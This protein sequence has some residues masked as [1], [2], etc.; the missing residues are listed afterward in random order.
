M[1]REQ[2]GREGGVE[3]WR[4]RWASEVVG[5]RISAG[6]FLSLFFWCSVLVSV[7]RYRVRYLAMMMMS[8]DEAVRNGAAGWIFLSVVRV[9]DVV[10]SAIAFRGLL[11]APPSLQLLYSPR[12]AQSPHA[13]LGHISPQ[14]P[15]NPHTID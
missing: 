11:R 13:L 15:T 9:E 2:R 7:L 4:R 3:E 5:R 10:R 6:L 12:Y 14:I 1:V 8:D